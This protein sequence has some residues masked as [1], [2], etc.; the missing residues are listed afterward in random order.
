MEIISKENLNNILSVFDDKIYENINNDMSLLK[1]ESY[2]KLD[3]IYNINDKTD[4]LS[5]SKRSYFLK[6]IDNYY[7]TQIEIYNQRIKN[8]QN[9]K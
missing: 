4:N 5:L 3:D 7:N 2:D 9:I 8:K 6:F 1:K